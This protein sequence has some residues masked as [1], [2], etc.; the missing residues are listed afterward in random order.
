VRATPAPLPRVWRDLLPISQCD[1]PPFLPFVVASPPQSFPSAHCSRKHISRASS[2]DSLTQS[3]NKI[4]SGLHLILQR[5]QQRGPLH[6]NFVLRLFSLFFPH[7]CALSD[8][9]GFVSL[10]S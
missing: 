5:R 3:N 2:P 1:A 4:T 9:T 6:L 8:P 7:P 10:A